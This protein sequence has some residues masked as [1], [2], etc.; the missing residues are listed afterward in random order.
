MRGYPDNF[1]MPITPAIANLQTVSVS[2]LPLVKNTHNTVVDLIG[3]GVIKA[4]DL[5]LTGAVGADTTV[6]T[7]VVDGQ[8]IMSGPIN[9]YYDQSGFGGA[10]LFG[11]ILRYNKDINDYRL[12][13]LANVSFSTEITFDVINVGYD[14]VNCYATA[15]YYPVE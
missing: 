10:F 15:V 11:R 13:L 14:N 3:R 12:D 6:V 7:I 9:G 2:V 5:L 4:I 8:S 1:Y